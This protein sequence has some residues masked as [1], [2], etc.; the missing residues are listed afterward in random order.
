[1]LSE[2]IQFAQSDAQTKAWVDAVNEA[3]YMIA[4]SNKFIEQNN[5]L[6]STEELSVL[7]NFIEQLNQGIQSQNK[8]QLQHV[9][10]QMNQSTQSI[11]HRIMDINIGKSLEGTTID[12]S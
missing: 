10:D 1:M 3:Q 9:I 8:E 2:S 5:T 4:H 12:L 7:Q 11:A 6:L